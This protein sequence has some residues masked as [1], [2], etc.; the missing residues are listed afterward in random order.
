M[1]STEET[2]VSTVKS[3]LLIYIVTV[4]IVGVIDLQGEKVEIRDALITLDFAPYI[5]GLYP[6]F[7]QFDSRRVVNDSYTPPL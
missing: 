4:T 2:N 7:T 5:F 3:T 6:D 1:L